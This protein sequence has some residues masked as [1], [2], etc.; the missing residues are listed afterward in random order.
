MQ[1]MLRQV[2]PS[3]SRFST[4]ATLQAELSRADSADIAARAG[5]DDDQ[6][7]GV[8]HDQS[9]SRSPSRIFDRFLDPDEEGHRFLAVDDPVVIGQRQIHHRPDLDLAGDRDRPF[10]NLVHAQ[11]GGLRRVDD[12]RRHQRAV[13]AAIGDAEGAARQLV[14]LELPV[15]SALAEVRRWRLRSG[16]SSSGPHRAAPGTTRPLGPPTAM[17]ICT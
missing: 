8:A 5:A 7:E 15:P 17:P 10:L 13:D 11:N 16:R 3:V 12:R 14:E 6:I 2:P 9:P 1:P 4:Q